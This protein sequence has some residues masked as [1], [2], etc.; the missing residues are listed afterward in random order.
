[1]Q[2]SAFGTSRRAVAVLAALALVALTAAGAWG[3]KLKTASDMET[4]DP[5]GGIGSATAQCEHG[6]KAVSGGFESVGNPPVGI[7]PMDSLRDG[8][9]AWTARGQNFTADPA[10]LTSFAYCRDQ[11][12]KT[13]TETETR[14]KNGIQ[15]VTARCPRGT[16][17][18]SGGFAVGRSSGAGDLPYASYKAGKREW[19]VATGHFGDPESLTAQVNCRSGRKVKTKQ[20]T[21]TVDEYPDR[22]DLVVS[23]GRKRRVVSGGFAAET[24]VS[25]GGP[26]FKASRRDSGRK[27]LV[28]VVSINDD[29]T[30]YAY[31][32]RKKRKK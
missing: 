15:T 20:V 6:T 5:A 7:L 23:C 26:F 30:A 3:A 2:G 31:C 32:E 28:S 21:E 12:L 18:I 29:V 10:T 25:K 14:S 13:V 17:A 9:R 4:V 24:P 19:T 22:E 1:M 8:A 11:K 27:W 16:K